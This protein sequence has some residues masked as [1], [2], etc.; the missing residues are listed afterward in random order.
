MLDEA[1]DV[2]LECIKEELWMIDKLWVSERLQELDGLIAEK[3]CQIEKEE[4]E[5]RANVVFLNG[6]RGGKV[7]DAELLLASPVKQGV[8]KGPELRV[9]GEDE[10]GKAGLENS[11]KR[12]S[13]KRFFGRVLPFRKEMSVPMKNP[14]LEYLSEDEIVELKHYRRKHYNKDFLERV[15]PLAKEIPKSNGSRFYSLDSI[16]IGIVCDEFFYHSFEG[17]ANLTYINKTNFIEHVDKLDVFLIVTTW[18]GLDMDWK[19]LGNPNIKRHREDLY[20]II[21]FYK[22]EGI[23]AVFFSKED[24]VNYEVF[25]D[26]ARQCD[27]IFTTARE[28]VES[29]RKACK[30]EKVFVWSFG[31][32][33]LYHNPIGIKKFPKENG[34]LFAGSWYYKYP[35]RQVDTRMIFDG[36]IK[37]N[38]ELRIIDRN[39]DLHLSQ[40][41]FPQEYTK[42]TS[43]AV[44]HEELQG[45]HKLFNWSLNFNSVKYSPTMF[46]NRIYELQALGN[47]VLSNYSTAINNKFPNVPI[48]TTSTDVRDFLN[49]MTA[50]EVYEKQ[51]QGIRRVMSNE[52]AHH[53]LMELY[54]DLGIPVEE[55]KRSVL[56]LVKEKTE[57]VVGMFERQSY[58]YKELMLESELTDDVKSLYDMVAFYDEENEYG[59]FYLED[60]VNGFKFT[61][62]DYITKDAYY[63]LNNDL[64]SGVEFDYVEEFKDKFKTLFWAEVFTAA[65]LV[66]FGKSSELLNGFSI[67]CRQVNEPSRRYEAAKKPMLS[68]IVPVY[69]NGDF[70]LNKCFASLKRSSMFYELEIVLVDDGSSDHQTLRIINELAGNFSNVR[71]YFYPEGGSGSASRPRNK[72]IELATADF[73]TYLDPDN[74]AVNDGFAKLFKVVVEE[75]FDIA[76]GNMQRFSDDFVRFSYYEIAQMFNNRSD[77]VHDR[78]DM[79]RFLERNNLRAMSIQALVVRKS[80]VVD[81]DLR[82]VEGAIGQ[83]T[84]FF[85]E[86]LMN[87]DCMKVVDE[88]IHVYYAA[89]DG[90]SVNKVGKRFF[91]KYLILERYRIEAYERYGVLSLF[92]GERFEY[93]FENWYLKKL[94]LVDEDEVDECI[95]VLVEIFRLYGGLK[96]GFES[97][98]MRGFAK[99]VRRGSVRGIRRRFC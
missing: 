68:V 49:S 19:G 57:K 40:H 12:R 44:S 5:L 46:A 90:S 69:N 77:E 67:D 58:S 83:D 66:G 39:F 78:E 52:T 26:V 6:I 63:D 2:C 10:K 87:V 29:Y 25:V 13:G 74:E 61:D 75:G 93:Y 86:L 80:V 38:E 28:K 3:V 11:R 64:C 98:C 14:A 82:M 32:N 85:L 60:M 34:V 99:L 76:V 4:G 95:G 94:A 62:S 20:D 42:Y 91:E 41:L 88:D 7:L 9:V 81:N 96:C 21:G 37:S 59:D 72:G 53:R 27:F 84:V 18:K 89:V 35:E 71:V 24:P 47:I 17:M 65:E 1:L 55:L 33:P 36:I 51:L 56:V 43:P 16:R 31:V 50:D 70:L 8:G 73:I 97:R 22:S 79:R 92:L 54:S 30:N 15:L 45:I 23:P 48:F